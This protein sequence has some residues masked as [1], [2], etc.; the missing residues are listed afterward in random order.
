MKAKIS[1]AKAT[2]EEAKAMQEK[3]QA[4]IAVAEADR[5]RVSALLDYA[6]L[7]APFK[8]VVTRRNINTGDFVQPPTAGKGGAPFC[9]REPR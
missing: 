1:T 6:K 7:T 9:H 8:G 3:A 4:D 5:E 2:W